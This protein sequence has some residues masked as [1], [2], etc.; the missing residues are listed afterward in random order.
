MQ[1]ESGAVLS[2][3]YYT[4]QPDSGSEVPSSSSQEESIHNP[5][6]FLHPWRSE[7]GVVHSSTSLIF[8]PSASHQVKM[9]GWWRAHKARGLTMSSYRRVTGVTDTYVTMTALPS[10]SSKICA[11]SV[12]IAQK[13]N[14]LESFLKWFKS[15]KP[16]LNLTKLAESGKPS[17]SG[18]K[19][20]HQKASTK[21][22]TKY[23]WD[24]LSGWRIK[25]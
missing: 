3:F 16:Q 2:C 22:G 11:H 15:Q 6:V 20:P 14:H 1:K 21:K 7:F 13:N 19:G 4:T 12:A 25:L 8:Q 9:S 17:T 24:R 5:W 10:K 18:K 23:I